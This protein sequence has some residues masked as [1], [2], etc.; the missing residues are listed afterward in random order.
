[1]RGFPTVA[2]LREKI[3]NIQDGHVMNDDRNG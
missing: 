2:M 3:R 1:M